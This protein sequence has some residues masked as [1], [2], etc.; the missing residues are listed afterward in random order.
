MMV[1]KKSHIY[2]KRWMKEEVAQWTYKMN[3]GN[4][5]WAQWIIILEA[6]LEGPRDSDPNSVQYHH[7]LTG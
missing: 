2:T 5:C 1:G 7:I 4:V 3:Q 6:F